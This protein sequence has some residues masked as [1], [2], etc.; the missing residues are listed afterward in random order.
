MTQRDLQ[1]LSRADLVEMMLA[2][3]RENEQLQNELALARQELADRNIRIENAG[4]LA[5]AALSLNGVFEAAQAAADQYLRGIQMR[6]R[7]QRSICMQMEQETRDKCRRMLEEAQIQAE[8]LLRFGPDASTHRR[9]ET[10]EET[11]P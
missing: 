4:S 2:L 1:R 7:Q 3:S 11:I 10:H 8:E 9:A 5:E 6:S